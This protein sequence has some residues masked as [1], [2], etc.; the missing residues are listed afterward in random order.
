MTMGIRSAEERPRDASRRRLAPMAALLFVLFFCIYSFF[1]TGDILGSG[2][3]IIRYLMTDSF[4]HGRGF[5]AQYPNGDGRWVTY[6]SQLLPKYGLVHPLFASPLRLLALLADDRQDADVRQDMVMLY[7]V[8]ADRRALRLVLWFNPILAALL[9]VAFYRAAALLGYG[10]R[11]GFLASLALGLCTFV[12]AY[13]PFFFTEILSALLLFLSYCLALRQ[14]RS[15]S[16][17]SGLC[18]GLL[19]SNNALFLLTAPVLLWMAVWHGYSARDTWRAAARFLVGLGVGSL[20]LVYQITKLHGFGY[21]HEPGFITPLFVGLYGL[22][23]SPGKSLFVFS[24]IALVACAGFPAFARAHGR[25]ALGATLLVLIPFLAYAKW[26][27]WAGGTC[28]GPRFLLPIVPLLM[29]GVLPLFARWR[30]LGPLKKGL[31]ASTALLSFWVQITAIAA[32]YYAWFQYA[33]QHLAVEM[34]DSRLGRHGIDDPLLLFQVSL[35]YFPEYCPPDLQ[36]RALLE[37]IGHGRLEEMPP[38]WIRSRRY[39]WPF[40]IALIAG[41]SFGLCW[42][43]SAPNTQQHRIASPTRLRSRSQ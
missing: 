10:G 6:G 1:Y 11:C 26:Y 42:R 9:C 18:A 35:P 41:A 36:T 19:I 3:E 43:M 32:P 16:I 15:G 38:E 24:P 29:L 4:V 31:I 34:G 37:I 33:S 17:L 27:N 13:T 28:W 2:D 25:A 5:T 21:G 22:L 7:E 12:F 20:F 8:P 14:G 23:L 39:G 40:V 30:E